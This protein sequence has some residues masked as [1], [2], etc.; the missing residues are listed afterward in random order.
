M[1]QLLNIDSQFLIDNQIKDWGY[2]EDELPLTYEY[3][4][5]WVKDNKNGPLKYLADERK[6][7]RKSLSEFYPKFQ[8]SLV[9]L[10]D[11]TAAAKFN[12]ENESNDSLKVAS[13]TKGFEGIDYHFWIK[14]RLTKIAEKIKQEHPDLEYV[15]SIDAQPVLERDMAYKAGLGWFGKNSMLISK[16]HGSFSI[17]GSL[18]FSEK[19]ELNVNT[20]IEPDHCGN[21]TACI[22]TCPT[23]AILHNK[24]IDANKC[25]STY[26]IE[27]FKD[28][29]APEG[30]PTKSGEVFGCDI[31]Q[32]VCPWNIKPLRNT[33][34]SEYE[35]VEWEKYFHQNAQELYDH[36]IVMSNREY[37]RK[38]KGTPLERTGRPG[39]LKNL[40]KFLN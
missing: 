9:F 33:S 3:F 12:I 29:P 25:I 18:L 11:Y 30:F 23:D 21:C 7:T 13:Y 1:K 36:I 4:N 34:S 15:T 22:D 20:F 40:D 31:C 8:S 6:D 10:F 26:T 38:F 5:Q 28:A 14:D 2:L 37:R 27:L 39:M 32:N 19:L 17:I 35:E 16:K 24:T